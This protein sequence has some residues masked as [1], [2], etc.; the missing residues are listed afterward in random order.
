[1]SAIK[2]TSG[3]SIHVDYLAHAQANFLAENELDNFILSCG[4]PLRK[5]IRVNTLKLS[6]EEFKQI[7]LN[8]QWQ[9]T[10]I[11]WCK[12]AF[13][14]DFSN[15]KE[16]VSIGNS[17]EHI[18]GL[19]YVQESSSMLPPVALLNSINLAD[20][21]E[22]PLVLDMAA[23]PGSK[24][25]QIAAMLNNQGIV[26]ANELSASRLKFLSANLVRSGIINTAMSHLDARKIGG[27]MPG[28]FDY[29]LLDA[30]C[31]CEGTVR[32]D[33]N[34]LKD[35]SLNKVKE[36]AKLQK[37]LILSAYAALKP[38][39]KMV[40]S[41]CTLS[42]EENQHVA[43]YLVEQ[44][45][46]IIE[47]L[48]HL[49][50]G[51]NKVADDKG[52]LLVLPHQFD[53]EG[54]FIASFIKPESKVEALPLKEIYQ[55]P[56]ID[57]NKKIKQ[58]VIAYY[59]THFGFEIEIDGYE[60]LQRDK[61]VWLFSKD[62]KKLNTHLKVNRAGLKIAQVYPNKIRSTHEFACCLGQLAKQQRVD[63]TK[64]QL[65]QF[66]QGLNLEI[67]LQAAAKGEVILCYQ[68][69]VVGLGQNQKG[70]V[71]NGLS[72]DLVKDNFKIS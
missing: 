41:T 4:S 51:A 12:E 59:Q 44:T 26:L 45:D 8:Y 14:I 32:K 60:L 67:A 39:G 31:G 28:Q 22:P 11:P 34:A 27:F 65:E 64:A 10:P 72:R 20:R 6:V 15:D 70:K 3:G 52:Y 7:A 9:L 38:G 66:Y 57:I 24:T 5:S 50:E 16:E 48:N 46:A 17:P 13:W 43:D 21:N 42:P 1:L 18:Q 25:T 49:F 33:I 54:F 56:F 55:S 30:P 71:K 68:G 36:I 47:P 62:I 23:A 53:S 35:W 58:Q 63:L 19:F 2:L 40:Y 29:V 69:H 61:E 37:E